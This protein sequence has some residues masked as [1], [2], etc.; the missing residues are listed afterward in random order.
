MDVLAAAL[1]YAAAGWHV[2]PVRGK[3]PALDHAPH[4]SQNSTTDPQQ[5]AAWYTGSS[6]LGVGVDLAKS[7]LVVVDG[8]HLEL[9]TF[10]ARLTG[11]PYRGNRARMSW[12]YRVNGHPIPQATHPWGDV[13]SAGGYVV[14]PPSPHDTGVDYEW[15]DEP[16]EAWP[17]TIPDDIA[18]L[19]A[20]PPAAD[21]E[22]TWD[23]Q[24]ATPWQLEQATRK[25]RNQ[26]ERV[27]AET[28]GNRNNALNQAALILGHHTPHYLAQKA[29][30][31]ALTW[32][33]RQNGLIRDDGP[34]QC[35]ATIR[36]GMR[37][38]M[39][40]PQQITQPTHLNLDETPDQR[41]NRRGYINWTQLWTTEAEERDHLVPGLWTVGSACCIYSPAGAGKSLLGLEWASM[42]S[43]GQPIHGQ[44]TTPRTVLYLDLENDQ[45]LLRERLEDMGLTGQDLPNLHYS[46]L[47]DWQPLDT[48]QGGAELDAETRRLNVDA[49]IID[50]TS[51]MI[52]GEEN[53]ADT[54]IN[55]F[56]HTMRPLKAN[57][58]AV[59]R[60][61]HAGKDPAKGERGSSAKRADVDIVYRLTAD[62]D[63]VTL[64][65]EKNRLHLPGDDILRLRRT[66]DP[67]RHQAIDVDQA[68]ARRVSELIRH[69][70]DLGMPRDAGRVKARE[71]F[72]EHGISPGKAEVF[73]EALRRYRSSW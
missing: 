26:A 46:L 65:R 33:A 38:G 52:N 42:L 36:S 51:R 8:D 70:A 4:W 24:P 66:E 20:P 23:R 17:P 32:A 34:A 31:D 25:L 55:L 49:V 12:L 61:D 18:A 6:G 53:T 59:L 71:L 5:I 21:P 56:R 64:K 43:L 72:K 68:R 13:K 11:W 73:A 39:K 35:Q 69:M 67:L 19:I 3:L 10:A 28:G 40:D 60:L 16:D 48:K 14:L 7:G 44:P 30:T 54:F 47:G 2:F 27:A 62:G 57:G 58:I 37:A 41:D 50:T 15:L 9:L 22:D 1:T 63:T 29:I 45:N